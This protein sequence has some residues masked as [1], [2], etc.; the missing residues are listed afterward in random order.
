MIYILNGADKLW[1]GPSG[2]PLWFRF[3]VAAGAFRMNPPRKPKT[4]DVGV[5]SKVLRILEAIESS[6]SALHL[7]DICA[8]TRINKTTAYRFVAHLQREGYLCR[9]EA[10]HYSFGTKLL[11]LG[12][13]MDPRATL[14]E[15]ARPALRKLWKSTQE[16]VNLAVLD[17]GMVLYV[18]VIESPH[19]FRMASKAGMRR[20]VYST[21][22]GKALAAFLPEDKRKAALNS[23]SFQ[24]LTPQ[25]IITMARFEEE[26]RKVRR[27]GYA[28][29]EEESVLG[30]RCVSAPV[31]N[32]DQEPVAAVS[33]SGP[34]SR[35]C[36]EQIPQLGTAVR[37]ASQAISKAMSGSV[38]ATAPR[39]R[40]RNDG[41]H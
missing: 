32:H 23:Q 40:S 25:T 26:L 14:L 16:T 5:I 35:I 29:D 7:R 20:P 12:T 17:E 18:D 15:M 38:D 11:Q 8:Q 36:P 3:Y 28:V 6:P 1:Y 2:R 19:V 13:R 9:D 22:L 10:G 34:C 30:A 41:R 21:A 31:L 27:S 24:S 37:K 33:L 39:K 4:A